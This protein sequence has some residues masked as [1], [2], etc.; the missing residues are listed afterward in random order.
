MRWVLRA[1]CV[2][3]VT[4][5]GL[6]CSAETT[7]GRFEG[8]VGPGVPAEDSGQDS[9]VDHQASPTDTHA[10]DVESP[11]ATE[12]ATIDD[13]TQARDGT[14]TDAMDVA[15]ADCSA[16]L[17]CDDVD[18]CTTDECLD[19]E[20]SHQAMSP[21]WACGAVMDQSKEQADM[22]CN[23]LDNC[24]MGVC[25]MLAQTCVIF[26]ID[27]DDQSYCTDDYCDSELGCQSEPNGTCGPVD[28]CA[29]EPLCNAGLECI[30]CTAI[31]EQCFTQS[32]CDA[33]VDCPKCAANPECWMS[34]CTEKGC[35]FLPDYVKCVPCGPDLPPCDDDNACTIDFCKPYPVADS[36]PGWDGVC[37]HEPIAC[38][39]A[40]DLCKIGFCDDAKIVVGDPNPTYG[41]CLYVTVTC[42]DGDAC[43]QDTCDPTTGGCVAAPVLCD[44]GDACSLDSCDPTAGC[45]HLPKGCDDGDTCTTDACDPTG[46]V[47]VST[48]VACSDGDPCTVDSCQPGTGFCLHV[49][50]ACDDDNPCTTGACQTDGSCLQSPVAFGPAG[51]CC[52][53]SDDCPESF[54]KA[55][56]CESPA[57]CQGVR[58]DSACVDYA[59]DSVVVPD[60]SACTSDTLADDCWPADAV[61]CTGEPAQLAPTCLAPTGLKCSLTNQKIAVAGSDPAATLKGL[62]VSAQ[63]QVIVTIEDGSYVDVTDAD[64]LLLDVV[65][66]GP[67]EIANLDY[68]TGIVT[69][70]APG[71]FQV[72][73]LLAS[74]PELPPSIAELTVVGATGLQIEAFEAYTPAPPRVVDHEL[75]I[76]E[77]TSTFQSGTFHVQVAFSGR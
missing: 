52:T 18:P 26:A 77:G 71:N 21:C 35:E 9:H 74:H 3:L 6:A 29:D 10:P 19:G 40:S 46:G 5:L 45:Q 70:I 22:H 75:A 64:E 1:V 23:E 39:I 32:T 61:Y 17:D 73:C 30:L 4:G 56:A 67:G 47:C 48:A 13:L 55:A 58:V 43:T 37:V 69:G 34:S 42:N 49:P 15:T 59:C 53:T 12:V 65:E 68:A 7:Q 14:A 44:D 24:L 54:A 8:E 28:L 66:S 63:L 16:D 76:I 36:P 2:T 51:D 62:A 38:E 50:K 20:C 31:L 25:D 72:M 27:C 60:D 57:S 11:D 41:E 33:V